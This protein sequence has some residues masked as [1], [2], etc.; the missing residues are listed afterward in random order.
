MMVMMHYTLKGF[1]SEAPEPVTKTLRFPHDAA[2]VDAGRGL[3]FK[4]K[5]PARHV[6]VWRGEQRIATVE[7][8][9]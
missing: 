3:L 9:V 4:G 5:T 1:A 6:E 8:L 2:A 7:R